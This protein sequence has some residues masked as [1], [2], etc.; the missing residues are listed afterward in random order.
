MQ[1][2]MSYKFVFSGLRTDL[3]ANVF[4]KPVC[5]TS[6]S[7]DMYCCG[8]HKAGPFTLAEFSHS[9]TR[10][11]A[12]CATLLRDRP[13]AA[14]FYSSRLNRKVKPGKSRN[15]AELYPTYAIGYLPDCVIQAGGGHGAEPRRKSSIVPG[16]ILF[17][18][19]IF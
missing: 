3:G 11:G 9:F 6:A 17:S 15:N 5:A 2:A 7:C 14:P 1:H 19:S 12:H 16:Y 8:F 18:T 10:C 4:P 13:V